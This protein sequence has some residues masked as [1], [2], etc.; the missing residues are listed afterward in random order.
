MKLAVD[1]RRHESNKII[2]EFLKLDIK[3]LITPINYS[4]AEYI[5]HNKTW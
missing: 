5:Y 2:I 4:S 3:M 1:I